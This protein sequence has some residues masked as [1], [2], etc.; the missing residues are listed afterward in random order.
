MGVVERRQREKQALREE[1]LAAARELFA[2]HGY[3]SVSMRKIAQRIEYSP[4]TIYLYFKDKDEIIEELCEQTFN[5]LTRRLEKV[6]HTHPDPVERLKAGL[7]AYIEFGIE[8]P[9][10]YRI[11]LMM[12]ANEKKPHQFETSGGAKAFEYLIKIVTEC[13]QKG[14]LRETDIVAVSQVLWT[15]AHGVA[16]LMLCKYTTFP[17]ID[18]TRLIQLAVDNAVRG[19]LHEAR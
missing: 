11:T 19:F 4:T 14:L 17:W 3:E 6:I 18:K 7:K 1:I 8:H 10:H 16:S 5:L 15:A 13:V 2:T 9:V 12:P